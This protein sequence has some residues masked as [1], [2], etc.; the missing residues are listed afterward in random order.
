MSYFLSYDE[1][2]L[3]ALVGLVLVAR[4][5]W[6]LV[7]CGFERRT[8]AAE[9]LPIVRTRSVTALNR[10]GLPAMSPALRRMRGRSVLQPARGHRPVKPHHGSH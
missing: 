10:I 7:A 2:I 1:L 3:V 9:A 8:A 4:N 5:W 6:E